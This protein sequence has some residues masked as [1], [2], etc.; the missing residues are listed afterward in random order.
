MACFQNF[1]RS[2]IIAFPITF[3]FFCV[4][5]HFAFYIFIYINIF[6]ICFIF[7]LA[8]YLENVHLFLFVSNLKIVNLFYMIKQLILQIFKLIKSE[9][10]AFKAILVAFHNCVR[11]KIRIIYCNIKFYIITQV[12]K[13][14]Y[15]F[16]L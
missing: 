14:I 8:L 1:I 2:W 16:I 15:N 5:W 12:K 3:S 10:F 6:K 4:F 7:L 13:K 11:Q 9:T